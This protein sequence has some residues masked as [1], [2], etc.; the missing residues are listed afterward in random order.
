M[1]QGSIQELL[2]TVR[3]A[4]LAK[5]WQ[6]QAAQV[7]ARAATIRDKVCAML[8]LKSPINFPLFIKVMV[9]F[10]SCCGPTSK[11]GTG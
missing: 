11:P 3:L 6:D 10:G 7:E 4:Q 9:A 8:D 5:E 1:E 2:E